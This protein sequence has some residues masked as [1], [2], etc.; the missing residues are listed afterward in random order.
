LVP[1]G[2]SVSLNYNGAINAVPYIAVELK[3]ATEVKIGNGN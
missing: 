1:K 2:Q 3:V